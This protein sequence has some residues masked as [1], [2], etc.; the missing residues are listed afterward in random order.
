MGRG[1]RGP[2]QTQAVRRLALRAVDVGQDAGVVGRVDDHRYAAFGCAV[3][4][5]GGAQHGRPADIDVF[6]RIGKGAAR[7]GYGFAKWVQVHRQQID[8]VYAVFFKRFKEIGRAHSELQ[9]LKR[10]SYAVFGLKK[11]KKIKQKRV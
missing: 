5:G 8:T 9:S 4:L 1:V 3:V 10:T 2:V 11:K 7:F 6:D